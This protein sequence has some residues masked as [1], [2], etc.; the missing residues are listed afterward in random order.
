MLK[1]S[2]QP[3]S[4]REAPGVGTFS[5]VYSLV[6]IVCRRPGRVSNRRGDNHQRLRWSGARG[7]KEVLAC[8][9]KEATPTTYHLVSAVVPRACRT[10]VVKLCSVVNDRSVS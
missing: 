3:H 10:A 2:A 4:P 5:A 8:V 7:F 6:C 1:G 9:S